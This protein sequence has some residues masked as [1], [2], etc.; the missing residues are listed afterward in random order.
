MCHKQEQQS[1]EGRGHAAI[2]SGV[3]PREVRQLCPGGGSRRGG[4]VSLVVA[5]AHHPRDPGRHRLNLV[6]VLHEG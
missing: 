6:H 1:P 3:R 5:D 4:E 2:A